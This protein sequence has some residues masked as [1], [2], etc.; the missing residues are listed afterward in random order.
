MVGGS[1][2][3][4]TKRPWMHYYYRAPYA[5]RP[6]PPLPW[7]PLSC[8]PSL[9]P[10]PLSHLG[11][12]AGEREQGAELREEL[13]AS[14]PGHEQRRG[15]LERGGVGAGALGGPAGEQVGEECE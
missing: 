4:G 3:P 8:P 11:R 7:A 9:P 2:G 10:P 14:D 5:L 1:H 12:H 6:S 15:G 13:A